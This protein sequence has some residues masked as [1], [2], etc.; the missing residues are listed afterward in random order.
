MRKN[1]YSPKRR[2]IMARGEVI[3]HTEV[4]EA[5][6]WLC[7]LCGEE[8]NRFAT[9]DDYMRVTLDHIIPLSKGGEH[10]RD[11]VAPAHYRCNMAKGDKLPDEI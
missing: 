1:Y 10:I 11:N 9:R 8:I 7:H 2:A 5:Y 4:F 6:G 3:N